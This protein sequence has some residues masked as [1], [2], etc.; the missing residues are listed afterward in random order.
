M[1]YYLQ[2]HKY[3]IIHQDLIL[4]LIFPVR[5][6]RGVLILEEIKQYPSLLFNMLKF[7][8]KLFF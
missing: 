3:Q 1:D 2:F 6:H 8:L 4:L 7:F 5:L